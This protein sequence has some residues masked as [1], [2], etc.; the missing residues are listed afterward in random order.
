MTSTHLVSGLAAADDVSEVVKLT[1]LAQT[2]TGR[3]NLVD[4]SCSDG[5]FDAAEGRTRHAREGIEGR[6]R[7]GRS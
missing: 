6:C 5:L 4:L 3:F 7:G 2:R 1:L